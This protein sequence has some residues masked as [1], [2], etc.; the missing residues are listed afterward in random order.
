MLFP[1]IYIIILLNSYS[2]NCPGGYALGRYANAVDVV[3]LD[4]LPILESSEYNISKLTYQGLNDT[5]SSSYLPVEIMT[6]K[7]TPRSN[8]SGRVDHG[9]KHI[10]QDQAKNAYNKLPINIRLNKSKIIFNRQARNFYKDKALA[11]ALSL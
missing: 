11:W 8:N 1:V 9:E 5:N 4:W 3:N 6:Q 2:E 10:F 7:R